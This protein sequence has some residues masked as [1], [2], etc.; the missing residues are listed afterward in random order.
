V[1]DSI[2]GGEHEQRETVQPCLLSLCAEGTTQGGKTCLDLLQYPAYAPYAG[3]GKHASLELNELLQL[4]LVIIT[5][6]LIAVMMTVFL[7][8]VIV[9]STRSQSVH[10]DSE[11]SSLHWPT[12]E[13]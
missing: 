11:M 12:L 3:G 6:H 8:T 10:F 1:K 5:V 9:S 13:V 2:A 7:V 4:P